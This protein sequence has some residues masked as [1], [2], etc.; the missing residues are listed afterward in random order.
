MTPILPNITSFRVIW[1]HKQRFS[2]PLKR[3]AIS[4]IIEMGRVWSDRK[5]NVAL[6]LSYAHLGRSWHLFFKTLPVLRVIWLYKKVFPDPSKGLQF[7]K[8]LK[9]AESGVI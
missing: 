5:Q 7:Q 1:L 8:S 6:R 3:A 2:R 4:K 9:K